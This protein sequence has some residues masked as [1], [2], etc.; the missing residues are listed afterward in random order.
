MQEISENTSN[1]TQT[2][3]YAFQN[4]GNVSLDVN[5]PMILVSSYMLYKIGEF[6]M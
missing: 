2:S 6:D 5:D 3:S 4:E 1:L